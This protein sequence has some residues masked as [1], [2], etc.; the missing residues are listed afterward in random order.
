LAFGTAFALGL[1]TSLVRGAKAVITQLL[2]HAAMNV[3]SLIA[4]AAISLAARSSAFG[5]GGAVQVCPGTPHPPEIQVVQMTNLAGHIRYVARPMHSFLLPDRPLPKRY[6]KVFLSKEAMEA[7]PPHDPMGRDLG[8]GDPTAGFVNSN[9]L[10]NSCGPEA[11]LNLL[12]WHGVEPLEP[13]LDSRRLYEEMSTNRWGPLWFKFRG[14]NTPNFVNVVGHYLRKH[15]PDKY[16]FRYDH[17]NIRGGNGTDCLYRLIEHQLSTGH[18][19]AVNYKTK[20]KSGHFALIV[21]LVAV[22]DPQQWQGR[23]LWS[24]HN[25]DNDVVLFANAGPLPWREFRGKWERSY[26]PFSDKLMP[27]VKEHQYTRVFITPKLHRYQDISR[28]IAS[29]AYGGGMIQGLYD[30]EAARRWQEYRER[31]EAIE[32]EWRRRRNQLEP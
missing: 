18:P 22:P 20:K 29:N 28:D 30:A 7:G 26:F 8:F 32:R 27:L 19:V 23:T 11:A 24:Y 13:G 4:V 25:P 31:Q 5:Q 21:G 15:L 3:K 6:V 12:R 14:S 10:H 1:E 9:Q 17:G 2:E 16:E